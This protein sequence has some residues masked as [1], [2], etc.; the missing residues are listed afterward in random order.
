M[1]KARSTAQAP[2]SLDLELAL[3]ASK[4]RVEQEEEDIRRLTLVKEELEKIKQEKEGEYPEWM[5]DDICQSILIRAE[6]LVS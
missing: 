1:K 4:Q 2:T 6:K 5:R 3:Q